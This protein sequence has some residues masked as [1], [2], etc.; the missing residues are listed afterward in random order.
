[1]SH[2]QNN[3]TI[4]V[5]HSTS[6]N[7]YFTA[8]N[9]DSYNVY[10]LLTAKEVNYL[11]TLRELLAFSTSLLKRSVARSP[12]ASTHRSVT[13]L[14]HSDVLASQLYSIFKQEDYSQKESTKCAQCTKIDVYSKVVA[15]IIQNHTNHYMWSIPNRK[16]IFN[17]IDVSWFKQFPIT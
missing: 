14:A 7:L 15:I 1:M 8:G 3:S 2:L 16:I 9:A 17:S 11:I 4:P 12:S 10:D 5:S 6:I 13:N